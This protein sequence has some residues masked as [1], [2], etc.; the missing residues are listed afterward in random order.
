MKNGSKYT[1]CFLPCYM[2]MWGP[3][4]GLGIE[5]MP[6]QWKH[7]VLT[8]GPPGNSLPNFKQEKTGLK[9]QVCKLISTSIS[10]FNWRGKNETQKRNKQKFEK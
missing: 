5:S 6:L 7:R 8:G 10:V 2:T 4:P 9:T 1:F 3:V